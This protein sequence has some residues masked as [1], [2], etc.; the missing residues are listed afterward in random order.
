MRKQ[1]VFERSECALIIQG[2]GTCQKIRS[3]WLHSNR[4]LHSPHTQAIDS[5]AFGHP[6]L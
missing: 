6:M 2:K 4:F 1:L 5:L 3:A